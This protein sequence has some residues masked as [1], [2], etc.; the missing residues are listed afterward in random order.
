M[1]N[2]ETVDLWRGGD[3][4]AKPLTAFGGQYKKT[5]DAQTTGRAQFPFQVGCGLEQTQDMMN[6]LRPANEVCISA[7][8]GGD[9]FAKS[10]WMFGCVPGMKWAGLPPNAAAQT[11][12]MVIG[13]MQLLLLDV[14]KLAKWFEANAGKFG[15][16][17]LPASGMQITWF[18]N[19]VNHL[20]KD[21]LLDMLEKSDD[22]GVRVPVYRL[23]H[24]KNQVLD[25]PL[26]YIAVE[27]AHAA[28]SI[29]YG[30]RKSWITGGRRSRDVGSS[31]TVTFLT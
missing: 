15:L 1:E 19:A 16:Q 12:V 30:A 27:M 9:K 25:I 6:A 17:T 8:A 26:G 10:N 18:T 3:A 21:A 13:T 5:K 11:R 22:G 24:S 4:V 29:I 20:S 2:T 28:Q 31:P 23:S 14:V 7:I